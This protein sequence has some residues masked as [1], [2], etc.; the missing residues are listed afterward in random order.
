MNRITMAIVLGLAA[1]TTPNNMTPKANATDVYIYKYY[2]Y[3]YSYVK[4]YYTTWTSY[5]MFVDS[6]GSTGTKTEYFID[7]GRRR[8]TLVDSTFDVTPGYSYT[9]YSSTTLQYYRLC[10]STYYSSTTGCYYYRCK[11]GRTFYWSP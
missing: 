2:P 5:D 9:S 4:Q 7:S 11:C 1:L 10:G 6:W 8:W 3:D